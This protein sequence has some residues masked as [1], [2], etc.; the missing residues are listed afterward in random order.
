ML[1][2]VVVPAPLQQLG[3]DG[4]IE[5]G[6]TGADAANR[7]G[8]PR[9]RFIERGAG[10]SESGMSTRYRLATASSPPPVGQLIAK[11]LVLFL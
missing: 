11:A 7:G 4:R 2:H 10:R 6:P 3:D 9:Q 1:K 5:G 8:E